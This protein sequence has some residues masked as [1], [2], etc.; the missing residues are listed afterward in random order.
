[1][2]KKEFREFIESVAEVKDVKP[3]TSSSIRLDEDSG[4]TVRYQDQ[5]VEIGKDEN[6]TLGFKFVKLKPN[7]KSCE[8]GCGDIVENQVIERKLHIFP[9]KHWRTRCKTCNHTVS[10]D[11]KG[12]IEHNTAV[13]NAFIKWFLKQKK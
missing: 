9:V 10:P 8:L 2:D 4:G 5:W 6:P 11:G 1:M 12:F 13:H 3:A 7:F